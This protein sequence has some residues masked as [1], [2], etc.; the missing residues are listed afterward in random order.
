[1]TLDGTRVL[2]V[3][4]EVILALDFTEII[5]DHGYSVVGPCSRLKHA[6]R[7]AKED[8]IDVALLDVNLGSGKTTEGIAKILRERNIP[9]AFI[10]ADPPAAVEFRKIEEPL[11]RKPAST[12]A[13]MNC[14]ERLVA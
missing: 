12:K 1:M 2:V 5:E 10:T 9:I 4:D 14:I 7:V 8:N 11:I 3:E 6:E 13:L